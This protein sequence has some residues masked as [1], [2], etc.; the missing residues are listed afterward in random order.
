MSMVFGALFAAFWLFYMSKATDHAVS[1]TKLLRADVDRVRGW[2]DP[3]LRR[4]ESGAGP[5]TDASGA[6]TSVLVHRV[7]VIGGQ[8]VE[9][10]LQPEGAQTRADVVSRLLMPNRGDAGI[11]R[12]NVDQV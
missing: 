6:S 5:R 7:F 12:A 2:V 9:V 3:A 4:I 1:V 11:N 8:R 10:R